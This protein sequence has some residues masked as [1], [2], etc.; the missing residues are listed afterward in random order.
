MRAFAMERERTNDEQVCEANCKL[1]YAQ[2][3]VMRILNL[4][5]T[6]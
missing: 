1:K 3:N 4:P 2:Y 6:C 5:I